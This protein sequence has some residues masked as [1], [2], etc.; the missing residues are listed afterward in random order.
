VLRHKAVAELHFYNIA[1]QKMPYEVTHEKGR[2]SSA[3]ASN[4]DVRIS[5]GSSE[6]AFSTHA[7]YKFDKNSLERLARHLVAFEL[8]CTAIATLTL[9]TSYLFLRE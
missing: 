1:R 9:F 5:T 3:V 7:R 8:Q 4:G 6:I 2:G